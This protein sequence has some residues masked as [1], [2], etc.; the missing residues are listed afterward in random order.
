MTDSLRYR[1]C[2]SLSVADWCLL[3]HILLQMPHAIIHTMPMPRISYGSHIF[4]VERAV[5]CMRY[6][7]TMIVVHP[8]A[9]TI[10]RLS[11]RSLLL[12]RRL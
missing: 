4:A 9:A 8:I 7:I 1:D 2:I 11:L 6:I 5:T 3:A 12:C 10:M